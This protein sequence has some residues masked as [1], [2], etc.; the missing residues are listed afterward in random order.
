MMRPGS[1]GVVVAAT[2]ARL[3]DELFVVYLSSRYVHRLGQDTIVLQQ[4]AKA[5]WMEF[6]PFF[7]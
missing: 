7:Q 1:A 4:M 3:W 5:K 6:T 2:P